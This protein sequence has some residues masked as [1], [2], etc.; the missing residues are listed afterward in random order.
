MYAYQEELDE[1]QVFRCE[2]CAAFLKAFKLA[3]ANTAQ[4]VEIF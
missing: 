2:G 1:W 4:V 3:S